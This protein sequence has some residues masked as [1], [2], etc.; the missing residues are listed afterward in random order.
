MHSTL[1]KLLVSISIEYIY[2]FIFL[3]SSGGNWSR[4]GAV[5]WAD[6]TWQGLNTEG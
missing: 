3:I 6:K 4:L 1:G 5:G 2:T